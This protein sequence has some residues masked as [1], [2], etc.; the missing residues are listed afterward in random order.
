MTEASSIRRRR[1]RPVKDPPWLRVVA[2][3]VGR[4]T[5]LRHALWSLG[6]NSFTER[7]LKN[8]YRLKKFR[9]YY[10]TAKIE[11]YREWVRTPRRSSNFPY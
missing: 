7:E 9:E 2:E 8:L 1:G 3:K 6:I 10:E 4:G 11:F 5:P